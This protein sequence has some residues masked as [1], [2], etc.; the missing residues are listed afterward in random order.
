MKESIY[1]HIVDAID[2]ETFILCGSE[3]EGKR[4]MLDF[5]QQIGMEDADIVFIEHTGMGARVRSRGYV[6]RPGDSYKWLTAD[7][8]GDIPG[9]D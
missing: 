8:G 1:K 9:D 3:E 6:Y 5:M 4:L 7:Q 2:V